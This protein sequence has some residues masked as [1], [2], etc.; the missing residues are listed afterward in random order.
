MRKRENS[1]GS[2]KKNNS[3]YGTQAPLVSQNRRNNEKVTD[4]RA[5]EDNLIKRCRNGNIGALEQLIEKYQDRLFNAILRMVGNYDD[6][7]E[8][9]Q[10]A[11]FRAIKGLKKFRGNAGFYTWLF[12]IGINLCINH[13][14]RRQRVHF[15]SMHS[16]TGDVGHQAD[17][18]AAVMTDHRSPSPVQQ[19]QT[20]EEY[21][22]ILDALEEL[23]PP[24]RAVVILRDIEDLNYGQIARILEVPI[25]TVKSRLCRARS[26]LRVKLQT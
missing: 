26:Q 3:V 10:E 2:S 4:I 23:D 24:G 9:T 17:G 21:N 12:R 22:Q 1:I 13:R 15:A 7:Q 25:G 5:E 8:L 20:N 6:A 16:E 11:L 18:L 19:A 14:R